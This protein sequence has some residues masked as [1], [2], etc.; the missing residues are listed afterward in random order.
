MFDLTLSFDNGPEPET[1]P[2]V[3]DDNTMACD[4][5]NACT[6][7]DTCAAGVCAGTSTTPCMDGNVCTTD[8]CHPVMGCRFMNNTAPCDDDSTAV[9]LVPNR[10]S[11]SCDAASN[12]A[13]S[14]SPRK[15]DSALLP[16]APSANEAGSDAP[17]H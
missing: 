14:R 17:L 13:S 12:S 7:T 9:T 10:M 11:V 3:L 2:H 4:D 5:G 15:S 8:S 1:T 6:S 16:R